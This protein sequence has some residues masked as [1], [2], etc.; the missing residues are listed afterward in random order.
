MASDISKGNTP[1]CGYKYFPLPILA[2]CKEPLSVGA[3]D[4]RGL[5]R[6]V[7][8]N[9][10]ERIEQCGSRVI[11][12]SSDLI[13]D[14]GPK[15]TLGETT[16]DTEGVV[17]RIGGKPFCPRTAAAM[18]WKDG[19]LDFHALHLRIRPGRG[20]TI[21]RRRSAGLG[22]LRRNVLQFASRGLGQEDEDH[23]RGE[24]QSRDH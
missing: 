8:G 5:W 22:P 1:G 7:D 21:P 12:T 10:V 6:Q 24:H 19:I 15:S 9:H 16:N 14:S 4:I 20:K 2:R 18:R 11:V 3:D 17:F 13:L 23:N